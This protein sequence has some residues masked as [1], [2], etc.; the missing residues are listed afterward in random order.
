VACRR[1]F[2]EKLRLKQSLVV[3]GKKRVPFRAGVS[4][5]TLTQRQPIPLVRRSSA[6]DLNVRGFRIDETEFGPDQ[7]S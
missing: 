2:K 6:R 5:G 1:S 3:A 4:P 7:A